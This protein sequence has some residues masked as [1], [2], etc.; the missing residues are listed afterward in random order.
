[1]KQLEA[2]VRAAEVIDTTLDGLSRS[3]LNGLA[4][5]LDITFQ[6]RSTHD[7]DTAIRRRLMGLPRVH[8]II[9]KRKE[10]P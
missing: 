5:R 6:H 7:L 3:K 4:D 1:M 10:T 2:I 9:A 8:P